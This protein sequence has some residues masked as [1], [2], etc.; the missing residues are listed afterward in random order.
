MQIFVRDLAGQTL[1]TVA[2]AADTVESLQNQIALANG[3]PLDEQRLI[4]GGRSLVSTDVIGEC[5]IEDESTLFLS[6]GLEGG[7]KK[8]KKKTYT[9][10][11]KIKHKHKK[12]ERHVLKFYRVNET[13]KIQRLRR[14]C[15]EDVCGAGVFM[16]THADRYYCGKCGLTYRIDEAGNALEEISR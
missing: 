1:P 16:A 10:P 8:R 13:G 2:D 12:V 9:K 7:G 14:E 11:K 6:L 15:P 4:F 5:G 3:I